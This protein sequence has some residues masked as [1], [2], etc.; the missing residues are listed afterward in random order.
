[1]KLAKAQADRLKL[2]GNDDAD[3]VEQRLVGDLEV[4]E[5][6]Y[7]VV[8]NQVVVATTVVDSIQHSLQTLEKRIL[9]TEEALALDEPK[10]SSLLLAHGFSGEQEFLDNRLGVQERVA[11]KGML[12]DLDMREIRNRERARESA[13]QLANH[14]GQVPTGWTLKELREEKQEAESQCSSY[15]Q[16]LGAIQQTLDTDAQRRSIHASHMEKIAVQQKVCALWDR[17]NSLIGSHDGKRFRNFAQG[18]TFELLIAHANVHLRELSDR[19]LLTPDAA[20]PLD[21]AVMDLYQAGEVRSAR[22]LSGG[23]SFLVSLALSLGLSTI[24]SK[25]VQVDSLFLDEGFG[26]LDEE[27]LETALGALA[28]L[29]NQGKLV[30]IISHVGALQERIP[31]QIFVTPVAGGMSRIAGPGCSHLV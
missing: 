26:T 13:R 10:F 14:E 8:R 21:I 5:N 28:S 25:K 19:Y 15:D 9:A 1:V 20:K 11:L 22:N 27:T 16:R 23:E 6:L 12:E 31:V 7:E 2:F 4:A 30:G 24:A 18:L 29:R 3:E 17:L